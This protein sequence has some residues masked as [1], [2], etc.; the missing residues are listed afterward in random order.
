MSELSVWFVAGVSLS[1]LLLVEIAFLLLL[2]GSGRQ[3]AERLTK[4]AVWLK[5]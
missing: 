3:C 1:P 4:C 2:T 5:K